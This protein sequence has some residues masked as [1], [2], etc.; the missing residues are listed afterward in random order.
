MERREGINQVMDCTDLEQAPRWPPGN[1]GL[2]GLGLRG[3][4]GGKEGGFAL[5]VSSRD[6]LAQK[7]RP[8]SL[9]QQGH[10]QLV[11]WLLSAGLCRGKACVPHFVDVETA[12]GSDSETEWK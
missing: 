6:Q 11:K 9:R 1:W 4:V 10:C 7:R 8:G 3:W 12:R 5:R 2:K